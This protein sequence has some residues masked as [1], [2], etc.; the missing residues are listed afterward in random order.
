MVWN[1][2]A[3]YIAWYMA[4]YM[5]WND[6]ICNGMFMVWNDTVWYGKA[7]SEYTAVAVPYL[8]P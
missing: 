5:A 7:F 2:M 8:P 4:W 3:W 6:T 1:V